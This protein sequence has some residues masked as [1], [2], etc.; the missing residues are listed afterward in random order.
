METGWL[1]SRGTFTCIRCMFGL[2]CLFWLCIISSGTWFRVV[3]YVCFRYIIKPCSVLYRVVGFR[4]LLFTLVYKIITLLWFSF[5]LLDTWDLFY[6][7]CGFGLRVEPVAARMQGNYL[8]RSSQVVS[9]LWV[10]TVGT[11]DVRSELVFGSGRYRWYQSQ[12][13]TRFE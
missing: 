5:Q 8:D 7:C 11:S 13:D 4:K 10:S 9:E 1:D 6:L 12:G 2:W 3:G